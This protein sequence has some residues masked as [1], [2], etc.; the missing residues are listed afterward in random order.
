LNARAYFRHKKL[1]AS[2]KKGTSHYIPSKNQI[3]GYETRCNH[4]ENN[5][6]LYQK[7]GGRFS[8]NITQK[9][10]KDKLRIAVL[11]DSVAGQWAYPETENFGDSMQTALNCSDKIELLN[12]SLHG[13]SSIQK[14]EL[15]KEKILKYKPDV[16]VLEQCVNDVEPKQ[17]KDFQS[18]S[19]NPKLRSITFFDYYL[20]QKD[21]IVRT[22]FLNRYTDKNKETA[23]KALKDLIQM[24]QENKIDLILVAF[25]FFNTEVYENS[26]YKK[27][28]NQYSNE[29]REILDPS[30]FCFLDLKEELY[31]KNIDLDSVRYTNSDFIHMNK[32]GHALIGEII[33]EKLKSRPIY[34][35]FKNKNIVKIENI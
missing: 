17:I 4:V 3:L 29:I 11:G 20:F 1:W 9:K 25:P 32:K 16:L 2:I 15:F 18:D 22:Q 10:S 30:S 5:I 8:P 34:L 31:K 35:K 19:Y 14:I 6:C 28:L 7:D 27:L 33:A 21:H 13:Y 12:W 23:Y 26:K 24:C